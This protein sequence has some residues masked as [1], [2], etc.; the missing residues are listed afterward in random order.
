[1]GVGSCDGHGNSI[2]KI[3]DDGTVV[4]TSVE[5]NVTQLKAQL[6]VLE[7]SLKSIQQILTPLVD[8]A[9]KQVIAIYPK[10]SFRPY[11]IEHAI[12]TLVLSGVSAGDFVALL[13][14][15]TVG[16][17]ESHENYHVVSD[18]NTIQLSVGLSAGA[19]KVCHALKQVDGT[20]SS[21]HYWEQTATLNVVASPFVALGVENAASYTFIEKVAVRIN[22]TR[23]NA[24]NDD[25]LTM[26]PSETVGCN[27]A[28]N[29]STK[30]TLSKNTNT[31]GIMIQTAGIYKVCYAPEGGNLS[32]NYVELVDRFTVTPQMAR[33]V[34]DYASDFKV[35]RSTQVNMRFNYNPDMAVNGMI[36]YSKVSAIGCDTALA[37]EVVASKFTTPSISVLG[38]Y[39]LCFNRTDTGQTINVVERNI[40][41]ISAKYTRST[42]SIIATS[43]QAELVAIHGAALSIRLNQTENNVRMYDSV[44]VVAATTENCKSSASNAVQILHIDE[45]VLIPPEKLPSDTGMTKLCFAPFGNIN[46]TDNAFLEQGIQVEIIDP[47]LTV[48]TY[49]TEP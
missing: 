28:A 18:T 36:T 11:I 4:C 25:M 41:T 45:S 32:N 21:A 27:G 23:A 33:V 14:K 6:A 7:E 20:S 49:K 19:Y 42:S 47:E 12:P 3:N 1:M 48:M 8:R 35:S 46:L 31:V 43:D 40:T 44:A 17:V 22:V 39:R 29:A 9:T 13:P 5:G 24:T 2:A 10:Y 38:V 34:V 15:S 26:L 30:I 16:C 37:S